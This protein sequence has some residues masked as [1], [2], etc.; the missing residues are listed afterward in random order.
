MANP[1][2]ESTCGDSVKLPFPWHNRGERVTTQFCVMIS[3]TG[4]VTS[5]DAQAAWRSPLRRR[6]MRPGELLLYKALGG[7]GFSQGGEPLLTSQQ[8]SCELSVI[9]WVSLPAVH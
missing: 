2:A 8:R 1:R 6:G 5:A 9:T 3:W 4:S 7:L